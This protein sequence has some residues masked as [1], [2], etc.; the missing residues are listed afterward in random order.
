MVLQDLVEINKAE[1]EALKIVRDAEVKSRQI[2]KDAEDEV[3]VKLTESNVK[4]K[5][6]FI[7][8]VDEI[9][10]N[11][12]KEIDKVLDAGKIEVD[13]ILNLSETK[14]NKAVDLIIKKVV[15]HNGNN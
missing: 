2:I 13:D 9:V 7:A 3:N 12:Q 6:E 15:G 14:I 1:D 11:G 8:I 4:A 10:S 5:N